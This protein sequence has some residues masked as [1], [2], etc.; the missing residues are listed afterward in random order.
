MGKKYK[1]ISQSGPPNGGGG[2]KWGNL[3]PAP[4]M[5][6]PRPTAFLYRIF[7]SLMQVFCNKGSQNS[8]ASSPLNLMG[9]TNRNNHTFQNIN[10]Y[11][12]PKTPIHHIR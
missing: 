1:N 6:G 7:I 5:K 2:G 11:M 9:G 12:Q 10:K 8:I 4:A 3:P